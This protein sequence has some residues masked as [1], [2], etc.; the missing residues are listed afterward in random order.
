MGLKGRKEQRGQLLADGLCTAQPADGRSRKGC[1]GIWAQPADER[2]RMGCAGIWA[3]PADGRSRKMH[4]C[5]R[6]TRAQDACTRHTRAQDA[7]IPA[8]TAAAECEKDGAQIFSN[9]SL[10][11]PSLLATAGQ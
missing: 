4:A 1:A 8:A 10:I 9:D 6:H 11:R 2:S 7:T 3:Q 5:T